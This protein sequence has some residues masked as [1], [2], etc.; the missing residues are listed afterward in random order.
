MNT[1]KEEQ[2]KKLTDR[3]KSNLLYDTIIVVGILMLLGGGLSIVHKY[4]GEAKSK[5]E[6]DL[7]E[8]EFVNAS[9]EESTEN[10]QL[11]FQWA[12]GD[13]ATSS[14]ITTWY[15]QVS[16]NF[17]GL[18][19]IND[20]VVAWIYFENVDISYPVLFSGDDKYLHKSLY[21]GTS[22]SG[23]LYVQGTNN[24]DFQ[25]DITIIYGHNMR[26]LSMFGALRQY[27]EEG[28]YKTHQYF[29]ILTEDGMAYR[30]KVFAYFD[31]KGDESD[32]IDVNFYD[33]DDP[34]TFV[35]E[36]VPV[37]GETKGTTEM[38]MQ[39]LNEENTYENYLKT[40][41]KRKIEDT[42]VEVTTDD[43]VVELFTCSAKKGNRFTV[44]GVKVAEHDFN[45]V[46]EEQNSDVMLLDR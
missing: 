26:N 45:E 21:G 22:T 24:P 13:N 17:D 42:G 20:E 4:V 46:E 9:T 30:Y 1:E 15:K 6:Y 29:Q 2:E 18:N 12:N 28:F 23:S 37:E 5:K 44:Y 32:M 10:G 14:G 3:Q 36:M 16:V 38:E 33:P 34:D 8:N 7:L 41:N 27:K 25:D 31:I 35:T 39:I 40:I 19:Q 11:S 43:K